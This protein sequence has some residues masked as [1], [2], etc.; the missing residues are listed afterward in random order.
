MVY[1]RIQKIRASGT[2]ALI[3]PISAIRRYQRPDIDHLETDSSLYGV[4]GPFSGHFSNILT[5]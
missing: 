5:E 4:G 2:D 1:H 3:K